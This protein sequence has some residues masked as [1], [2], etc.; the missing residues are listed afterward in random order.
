MKI[1]DFEIIKISMKMR[2]PYEVA[3]NKFEKAD[4][5]LIRISAGNLHGWG[6]IA[7]DPHVTGENIDSIYIKSNEVLPEILLK[8][9]PF[10]K[11]LI[12]KHLKI[13]FPGMFSL[14]AGVDM[15][16]WD[17]LGKKAQL[18]I[19]KILGGYRNSI[20][21]SVTIGICSV[22]E[23][24][25]RAIDLVNQEFHILKIKGGKNVDEDLERLQVV[26]A[27]LDKGIKIRFDANQ[28]YSIEDALQFVKKIKDLDIQ[29]FEQ[30]T[31]K[32]KP[33]LLGQ[34]TN[35]ANIPI[36]A[37][38]SL[39]SLMDAFYLVRKGLIDL[40]N[41]KLMKVGGITEAIQVDGL[42]RAAG[43]EVMVGCMDEAA[44]GI[45]AGL[46]FA[47]SRKNIRFADLDGHIGLIDDPTIKCLS[48]M[49]GKLYPSLSDGFGWAGM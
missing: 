36:M 7:P 45:S 27:H 31:V 14:W 21:T 44:L 4:N 34:I 40:M 6:C 35:S 47:L 22:E 26:R 13:A 41:I 8:K 9:D 43:V 25:E 17:L 32:S 18:P 42:A 29:L 3:Y 12:L 30:P 24:L 49:K 33:D 11:A 10:R 28:G 1:D 46:H 48:I 2:D 16:L 5:L 37:D 39:I 19:W 23:T 15:A 38:E 20:S